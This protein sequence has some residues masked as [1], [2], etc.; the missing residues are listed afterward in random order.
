M[1]CSVGFHHPSA[2]VSESPNVRRPKMGYG[3]I[4]SQ[5][6]EGSIRDNASVDHLLEYCSTLSVQ[7][8][9]EDSFSTKPSVLIVMSL[10]SGLLLWTLNCYRTRVSKVLAN[11]GS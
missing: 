9:N 11:L 1:L 2:G 4:L 3:Q 10:G 6:S 8:P 7:Q 5:D